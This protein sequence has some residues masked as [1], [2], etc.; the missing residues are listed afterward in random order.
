MKI[1]RLLP[2][3]AALLV[4]TAAHAL[5][6]DALTNR[7]AS[8]GLK[9]AL[10]QGAGKA[11]AALGRSDGFLGNP[12]VR[13]PLPESLQQVE[14]MMRTFGLGKHADEL[15]TTMN[16]AAEAAV[17]EARA[18]L[19]N[20]VRQMSVEDAKGILTGGDDSATQYFRRTTAGPLTEKFRPVVKKAMQ[21]VKLAEKYD[22]FAGKAA[23]FGLISEADAQLDHYVT[24]KALDGL[25]LMI[26]EEEK[27]IR[28]DPVSAAGSLARKVFGAIQ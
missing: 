26:A 17:P 10:T 1:P 12:R 9:E 21:K 7:D 18:L 20:S 28:K 2:A 11:V 14:G 23:Q 4:A 13:I 3:L 27:A 16:R 24:Q 22:R 25:Y 8:G 6:L 19:V 15:V 5:S